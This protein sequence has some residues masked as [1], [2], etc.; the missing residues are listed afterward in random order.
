MPP[1][2]GMGPAMMNYLSQASLSTELIYSFVIILVS[3]MIYFGTKELY[4]LTSHTGIKYFRLSFLFFAISIFFRSLLK[5][6]VF[7]VNPMTLR[8]ILFTAGSIIS[9]ALVFLFIYFSTMAIF[10]L[11]YSVMCKKWNGRK[12][13]VWIFHIIAAILAFISTITASSLVIFIIHVI[14]FLFVAFVALVSYRESKNK[15]KKNS[16]YAVYF[17]L[18]VFWILNVV[19]ILIPNALQTYQ[20]LIYA[21][22]ISLFL[23]ILYKVLKKTP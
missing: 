9:P 12:N 5:F 2:Q 21:V 10:F 23:M 11:L 3:L 4:E 22:S 17:L 6:I 18:F 19:D 16:L 7:L 20:L 14:L 13:L 1:G 15:K 8:E